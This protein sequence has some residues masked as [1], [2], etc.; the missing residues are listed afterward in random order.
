[1]APFLFLRRSRSQNE[2]ASATDR[3]LTT[4][5][6]KEEIEADQPCYNFFRSGY[7]SGQQMFGTPIG[8]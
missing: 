4:N 1:M 5:F 2:F 3:N 7:K 6:L 8:Q